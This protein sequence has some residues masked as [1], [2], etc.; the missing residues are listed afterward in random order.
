MKANP[1]VNNVKVL[2]ALPVLIAKVKVSSVRK[3]ASN[4]LIE[5]VGDGEAKVVSFL[6][7]ATQ[8]I[9]AKRTWTT[10]GVNG[11]GITIAILN[12]GIDKTHPDLDDLDDDQA[13]DDP[14]VV[15]EKSFAYNETGLED[16]RDYNG[17]GT[18]VAGIAAGTSYAS[19]GTYKGERLEPNW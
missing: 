17:H 4:P 10:Y 7:A 8:T 14:K 19:N 5:H 2:K 3:L 1:D 18:F 11:S 12:T 15:F 6:D 13:T 9:G 16:P